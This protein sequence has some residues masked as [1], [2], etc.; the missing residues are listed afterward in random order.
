M[1]KN[2]FY[3]D[4]GDEDACC[5]AILVLLVIF[6][7]FAAILYAIT[8]YIHIII[9]TVL[10]IGYCISVFQLGKY[11]HKR[12]R[13]RYQL[14]KNS[15]LVLVGIGG[16][17]LAISSIVMPD[18][19]STTPDLWSIND[20]L[21]ITPDLL[22]IAMAIPLFLIS[23]IIVFRIWG[24]YNARK[25]L[26]K[27]KIDEMFDKDQIFK[28][29]KAIKDMSF[30]IEKYQ[31]DINSISKKIQESK[32]EIDRLETRIR[33]I[34]GRDRWRVLRRDELITQYERYREDDL[35]TLLDNMKHTYDDIDSLIPRKVLLELGISNYN[36][37]V[38]D[39]NTKK[40]LL[41]RRRTYIDNRLNSTKEHIEKVRNI[42]SG[43]KTEK[44]IL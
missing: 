1:K 27:L 19:W 29:D 35:K 26:E 33:D 30:E 44:I 28:D 8:R 39:K 4:R 7:V 31:S 41:I 2:I 15:I 13:D 11:L 36:K 21:L 18:L 12:I 3:N 17:S 20:L 9:T 42:I 43:K 22:S 25:S 14:T 34:C 6:Y 5:G 24:I 23:T 38:M 32:V 16:S 10:L 37:I 40:D